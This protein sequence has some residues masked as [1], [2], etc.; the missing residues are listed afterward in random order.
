MAEP[1][2]DQMWQTAREQ[3]EALRQREYTLLSRINF[4]PAAAI[5]TEPRWKRLLRRLLLRPLSFMIGRDYLLL[6]ELNTV[7]V[8]RIDQ[9]VFVSQLMNERFYRQF[10]QVDQDFNQVSQR[11][12]RVDQDFNRV[13]Q[14][15]E[16][17]DQDFN[18][19]SQRFE[20]VDQDFNQ[21]SRRFE[22][23]D[24]DFN[25]VSQRF[26]R[27]DQDFNQVGQRFEQVN[28]WLE[29]INQRL[30]EMGQHLGRLDRR[31]R[32]LEILTEYDYR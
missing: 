27:V 5:E 6:A 16:Q 4:R 30:E 11:F 28:Q 29:Q 3:L 13:S 21:V 8:A 24:R 31:L 7:H 1:S 19:V 17:V 14:R 9:A 12:E 26:E 32:L 15:F 23:V 22:Q 10:E 18:Q 20:R 25:Q 2:P